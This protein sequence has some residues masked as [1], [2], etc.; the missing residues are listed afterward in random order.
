M[1]G[2]VDREASLWA[3]DDDPAAIPEPD[4]DPDDGPDTEIDDDDD[5]STQT[6]P[7]LPT[8]PP[9]IPDPA[10]SSSTRSIPTLTAISHTS[11]PLSST[12]TGRGD[13]STPTPTSTRPTISTVT[14]PATRQ[15]SV[16]T[17]VS[18]TTT[19]GSAVLASLT[20]T[21]P[22]SAVRPE[23]SNQVLLGN[24]AGS[25]L[26]PAAKGGIAFGV[27]A[28]VALLSTL[29]FLFWKR[30]SRSKPKQRSP[31][32]TPQHPEDGIPPDPPRSQSAIMADLMA[33][34]YAT[35]NG[36]VMS[37]SD[38]YPDEKMADSPHSGQQQ[39]QIRASIASWLRRHHPLN[40]NPLSA[41]RSSTASTGKAT[42]SEVD[43]LPQPQQRAE[44]RYQP[45]F[46]SVWSE[47]SSSSSSSSI[48][49]TTPGVPPSEA[50]QPPAQPPQ[51]AQRN[52]KT[53]FVSVWS[54]STSSAGT[55]VSWRSTMQSFYRK[56]TRSSSSVRGTWLFPPPRAHQNRDTFRPS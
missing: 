30:R 42:A 54:D 29:A 5:A 49:P 25:G 55:P 56:S 47:S 24:P 39:P 22:I 15:S 7:N 8:S 41:R 40:L 38:A 36:G 48:P 46:I 16:T 20:A 11:I 32:Q 14:T 27:V 34:A 4:D 37:P 26:P 28:A 2:D 45:K 33:S 9:P 44:R 23:E 12:T 1:R 35:Q 51:P 19:V 52:D 3:R 18:A 13:Q 21:T 53:K 43:E 6:T 31:Q 10:S 17:S 50:S